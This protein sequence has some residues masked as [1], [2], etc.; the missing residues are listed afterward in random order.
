MV[1]N[2]ACHSAVI[3]CPVVSC[4]VVPSGSTF[5]R[6]RGKRVGPKTFARGCPFSRRLLASGPSPI[7]AQRPASEAAP[8]SGRDDR[9]GRCGVREEEGQEELAAAASGRLLA[10]KKRRAGGGRRG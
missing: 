2:V 6:L 5:E 3:L 1:W 4:P 10:Q 8:L 9:R 7:A